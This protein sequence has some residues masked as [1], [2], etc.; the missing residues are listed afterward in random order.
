MPRLLA[1]VL[2]V[3]LL[4]SSVAKTAP[5]QT[6]APAVVWELTDGVESPE[7]AYFDGDS[8][9]FFIS[10]IGG[11]GATGKDGD[12]YISRLT[13]DGKVVSS[14]WI[15]G[16]DA[17]KGLRT[18]RGRLWVS[19]IDRL[20]GIDI[21]KGQI[22]ATVPVPGAVFLNDV[23]CDGVGN[24]YVSDSMASKIYR[25]R[26]G[27]VEVF[28]EGEEYEYPNGLLV[29]GD[30]LI[31]ASWGK[32]NPDFSTEV[33]GRLYAL[34]LKTKKKSLIT[35]EPFGNLDGL[36]AVAQGRYLVGDWMAGKV[37]YVSRFGRSRQLLELPKGVAD[38]S[39][40][41]DKRLLVVPQMLENKVTAYE[42]RQ[43]A[44]KR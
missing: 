7:S 42:L 40:V 20:V 35:A 38:I 37:Y 34:D 36:E 28:V 18:Y 10:Q 32:P 33:P 43:S 5:P 31:V 27:Q 3:V 15:T 11:G 6:V 14:K 39:Y 1:L 24:V 8:G 9:T 13:L 41:R 2:T 19:D 21:A 26:E 44:P 23:A 12:G 30:Q 4:S 29:E 17:P 22:V 25:Y 16:L